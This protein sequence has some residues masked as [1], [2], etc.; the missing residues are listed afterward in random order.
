MQYK[1]PHSWYRLSGKGAP[2]KSKDTPRV[3]GTDCPGKA[4]DFAQSPARVSRCCKRRISSLCAETSAR[5]S[6]L[7]R[8][9]SR[10]EECSKSLRSRTE[11]SGSSRTFAACERLAWCARCCRGATSL[12]RAGAEAAGAVLWTSQAG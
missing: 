2:T 12:T 1:N 4:F 3:P 11:R 8:R 9:R 5:A 7:Q 10:Q 6:S